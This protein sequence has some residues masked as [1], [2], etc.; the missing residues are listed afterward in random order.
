MFWEVF[1]FTPLQDGMSCRAQQ[2]NATSALLEAIALVAEPSI[3]TSHCCMG[4]PKEVHHPAVLFPSKLVNAGVGTPGTCRRRLAQYAPHRS[5]RTTLG[6]TCVKAARCKPFQQRVPSEY[7]NVFALLV[8]S[9]LIPVRI[10]IVLTYPRWEMQ[11]VKLVSP[12]RKH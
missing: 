6:M 8:K 4:A 2:R 10:S 1:S 5:L 11:S 12:E 7:K 9:T 3:H